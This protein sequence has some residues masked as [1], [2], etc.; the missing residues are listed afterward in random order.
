VKLNLLPKVVDV[1]GKSKVAFIGSLLM[2]LASIAGTIFMVTTANKRVQDSDEALASSKPAYDKTVAKA[3]E[4]DA[5][6]AQP[7]VRQLLMDNEITHAVHDSSKKYPDLYN[8]VARYIPAFFRLTNMSAAPSSAEAST[9]TL[10]GTVKN[11]QQY[12]DVVLGLLRIPGALSVNRANFQG[13]NWVIPNLTEN[14]QVGR[15]YWESKG[16]IPDEPFERMS[17]FENQKEPT[18]Y[19]NSGNFGILDPN[20]TKTVRPGESL[21]TLNVTLQRNLT[22]PNLRATLAQLGAPSVLPGAAAAGA[23]NAGATNPGGA[24]PAQNRPG[25]QAGAQ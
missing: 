16:P 7:H 5:I 15:G 4:A 25:G 12:A 14:D 20:I 10:T 11:A 17:Y 6:M 8:E 3:A 2:V 21:I 1:T 19:L 23:L 9:L 18:G 22:A 24:N 13:D